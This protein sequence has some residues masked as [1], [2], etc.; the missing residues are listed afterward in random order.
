MSRRFLKKNDRGISMAEVMVAIMI[1][2]VGSSVLFLGMTTLYR[3]QRYS[4]QDSGS[5]ASLRTSLDRFEKEIRQARRMYSDSTD[6]TVHFWVD[7]DRDNQQDLSER[8]TYEVKDQGGNKAHLIR[9]TE[10]D[11]SS[12]KVVSRG[13]VFNAAASNFVY[14]AADPIAATLITVTFVA[15]EVGTSSP[16]RTVTT[17]VR[18]RNA[19][20]N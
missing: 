17:Q 5:L 14:N 9:S 6:K 16:E 7:Y 2:T 20:A 15:R 18:L 10:A 11:P 1:L 12:G 8:V 13:L 19:T 4:E 3:S